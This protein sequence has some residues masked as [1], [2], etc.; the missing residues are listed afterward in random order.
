MYRFGGLTQYTFMSK[1]RFVRVRIIICMSKIISGTLLEADPGGQPGTDLEAICNK[2]SCISK[3]R[4]VRVRWYLEATESQT[5][6]D[7]EVSHNIP[8][9]MS[10]YRF[11]RVRIPI[12]MSK[13][14]SGNWRPLEADLGVQPGTVL[15]VEVTH[16][17]NSCMSI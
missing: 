7:L 11:V 12:L 6:T 1:C 9:C 14:I 2:P 10:K 16:N 3:Y 13:I 8:S 4:Y 17:M 15:E 5:C